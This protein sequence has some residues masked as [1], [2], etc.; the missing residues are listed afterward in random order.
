MRGVEEVEI[1]LEVAHSHPNEG[2]AAP[3]FWV[4]FAAIETLVQA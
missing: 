4:P 1:D 2:V 3:S